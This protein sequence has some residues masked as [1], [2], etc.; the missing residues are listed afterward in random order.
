MDR[1]W[2]FDGRLHAEGAL[3]C[4]VSSARP[5][6]EPCRC[7]FP[8]RRHM[9]PSP[10]RKYR[11][12]RILCVSRRTDTSC[13]GDI[14]TNLFRSTTVY[15]SLAV[16]PVE[17]RSRPYWLLQ[18]HL[19]LSPVHGCLIHLFFFFQCESRRLFF[20]PFPPSS[21]FRS[22]AANC[23]HSRPFAAIFMPKRHQS[24]ICPA[25]WLSGLAPR[26]GLCVRQ[27]WAT[28]DKSLHADKRRN[29]EQVFRLPLA[30]T[31]CWLG[32]LATAS[33]KKPSPRAPI[34]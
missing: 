2:P 23:I 6:S 26:R 29:G 31:T 28:V 4:V 24:Q 5:C 20:S 9:S 34:V 25:C 7:F 18:K 33:Q 1:T 12:Y 27:S 8:H 19:L 17:R 21:H 30:L 15:S 14:C 10:E 22:T 13:S 3:H 16:L 32:R 11:I